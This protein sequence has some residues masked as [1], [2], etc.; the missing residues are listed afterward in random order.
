MPKTIVGVIFGGRSVEHEVSI[1][2][3]QQVMENI[4]KDKYEVVPIYISKAGEWFSGPALLAMESFKDPDK[5]L[6]GLDKVFLQPARDGNHLLYLSQR[7][8]LFSRSKQSKLDV[9]FPALHGTFGEDGCLQGLL[10]LVDIPYVGAAVVGSAV[11]MD[12]IVMKSILRDGGLPVVDYIGLAHHEW[13]ADP[14]QMIK[15]IE[16]HL[17]Y[18]LIVKPANLGSSI[19]ITHAKD[20]DGLRFAIDVASHYDRRIIVEQGLTDFIEINCS[21]MGNQQALQVSLCEQPVSWQEFLSYEDKY[22]NS[23][24]KQGMAGSSRKLPAP[25]SEQLTRQ[26]QDLAR[27]A[28]KLLDCRGIARVDFLLDKGSQFP[29]INE[30]NTMPGSIS[31]YLWEPLGISFGQLIER[32]IELALE[33]HRQQAKYLYS[34]GTNLLS[35]RTQGA[36]GKF[37]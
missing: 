16:A 8:G 5:L 35:L 29:Y 3:A 31:F 22:L 25:I 13:E 4:N 17:S 30:I 7:R 33:A 14:E 1:I 11:G 12:K 19:G 21:V 15:R 26:I 32:L 27:Q 20:Q 18:P 34:Y 9:V 6:A 23:G 10:E 28:F 36:K 37:G 2:T 24:G